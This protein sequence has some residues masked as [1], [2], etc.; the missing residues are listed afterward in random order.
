MIMLHAFLI[1]AFGVFV[2]LLLA[3]CLGSTK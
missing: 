3:V 1:F 2:G